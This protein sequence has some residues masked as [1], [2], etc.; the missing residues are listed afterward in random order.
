M[1]KNK[2]G[3]ILENNVLT[4]FWLVCFGNRHGFYFPLTYGN[5]S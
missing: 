2:E 5:E 3:N 4:D 1:S